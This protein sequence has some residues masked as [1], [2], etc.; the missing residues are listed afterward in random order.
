MP[1][2]FHEQR[3]LVDY[4]PWGHKESDATEQLTVSHLQRHKRKSYKKREKLNKQKIEIA[5]YTL[6]FFLL[7]G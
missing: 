2:K 5:R 4:S 7:R 3:N 1:G 6:F